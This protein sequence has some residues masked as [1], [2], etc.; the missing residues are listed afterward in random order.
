MN[1]AKAY[2]T[3]QAMVGMKLHSISGEA[4]I[5][6]VAANPETVT[7]RAKK[8]SG[9]FKNVKRRTSELQGLVSQMNL[10]VPIHVDSQL[11]G[12]GSS[13]NQPETIL[14]NMPDVEWTKV[15]GRKNIVW[16][17]NNTHAVGTLRKLDN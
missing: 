4:D 13:R 6:L 1:W 10:N 3:L 11:H 5:T 9:G 7:V 8:A 12:S 14:A 16:V 15:E 2:Q 17:G